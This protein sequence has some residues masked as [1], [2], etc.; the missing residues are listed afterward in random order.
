MVSDY[1]ERSNYE[2]WQLSDYLDEYKLFFKKK[3]IEERF[4]QC[5]IIQ[6][7]IPGVKVTDMEKQQKQLQQLLA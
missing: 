7:Y 6:I 2:I 3:V 4:C 1:R 5:A